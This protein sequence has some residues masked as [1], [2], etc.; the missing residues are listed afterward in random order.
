M[1]SLL[2]WI[3]FVVLHGLMFVYDVELPW[4]F[5]DLVSLINYSNSFVNP[6]VYVLR[7]PDFREAMVLCCLRRAGAPNMINI[8]RRSKETP[9]IELRTLRTDESPL[10]LMFKQEVLDTKL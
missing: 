5:Y 10:Q 7:I 1:L 6:V 9:A 2:C 3:P 8:N 4:K